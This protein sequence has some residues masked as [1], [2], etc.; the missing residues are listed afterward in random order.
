ML[1]QL[2]ILF[3]EGGAAPD[4]KT[5]QRPGG[6]GLEFLLPFVLIAIVFWLVVLRPMQKRQEQEAAEKLTNLEKGDKVLTIGGIYGHVVSVAEKEDE[7][8][9]KLDDNVRV[10]M[11]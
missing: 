11:V 9:V 4:G 10:K 2:L 3:A 8:V 5:G 1:L 6:G 7:V